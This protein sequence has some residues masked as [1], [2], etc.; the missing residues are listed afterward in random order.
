MG[1]RDISEWSLLLIFLLLFI[2]FVI[3]R[4]LKLRITKKVII[5]VARMFVQ[6]IMI[7]IILKY[8]FEWN[9]YFVTFSWIAFMMIAAAVSTIKGTS[10]KMKYFLWP[11]ILSIFIANVA[12][13]VY[14]NYIVVGMTDIF[15][16]R[17]TIVIMG[18][19]LGNSLKGNIVGIEG[20][21][22]DVKRNE[23][24]Y[25][26]NLSM[27][28]TLKEALIP[29]LRKN[30]LVTINPTIATMSTV[31][32]V[33]L[34]G[35]MTGQILGGSD[36]MIA[37]KYQIAIMVAIFVSSMI[38]IAAAIYLSARTAFDSYGVLRKEIFK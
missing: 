28:A 15:E 23:A 17:Y 5:S 19:L 26:Y 24:R 10:L 31:G 6:L 12:I 35:M 20:F 22:K 37:I 11:V 1:A 8:I 16:A 9:N 36:P 13:L 29:Y 7:G 38:S 32:I 30:L 3:D 18:M 4:Y 34:P 21:Y 27:G 2:P 33:S 14:F 25:F